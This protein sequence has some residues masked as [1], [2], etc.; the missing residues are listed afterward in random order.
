MNRSHKAQLALT[1]VPNLATPARTTVRLLE[2][3]LAPATPI[4]ELVALVRTDPGLA[5]EVLRKAPSD[6]RRRFS[7]HLVNAVEALGAERLKELALRLPLEGS[8]SEA[9]EPSHTSS[10]RLAR[11]HAL[12][13]AVAAQSFARALDY[14]APETAYAGGLLSS[15]G[16]LTLAQLHAA[17]LAGIADRLAGADIERVLALEQ[18]AC[19]IDHYDLACAL[20]DAWKLPYELRDV[21]EGLHM[22]TGELDELASNGADVT[23]VSLVRA[24]FHAA[25]Q[26]GFPLLRDFAIGEVP[27][28]VA[29]LFESIELPRFLDDVRR[30]VA[31]AVQLSRPASREGGQVV[32]LML[33][34]QSSLRSRLIDADRRLQSEHS[35]S[36]VL[37]YGLK[38]LGEND[39]LPG[40]M[41]K[42]MEALDLSRVACL[43]H[44][45]TEQ[46]LT[47]R[48]SCSRSGSARATEGTWIPLPDD[49]G[50]FSAPGLLS[51]DTDN[52]AAQLVLEL[53]GAPF[54]VIAPLAEIEPGHR[55]VLC[56][57]R[58]PGGE[59]PGEIERRALDLVAEQVSLILQYDRVV[60]E[61]ERMA[62]Q[63]PL[64][65]AA[66][67]RR[68][69]DR[70]EFLISQSERTG[71]PFTLLI[72]DLDH[73]K[74]FNDTM[75]HQTG[76]R[77]LQDLVTL[78]SS[79]VRKGDL[80][81]RYGGE[82]FVVLL[83][84]CDLPSAVE[85]ADALR[86][87]VFEYGT[88]SLDSYQGMQVSISMGA[89][90]WKRC[91]TALSLIGRAD[92]ALYEAKR[93]G[94]NRVVPSA[95]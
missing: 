31:D 87:R 94:R 75:G 9:E 43:E 60:R 27:A 44:D 82:E 34:V 58:G 41:Y 71:L 8:P 3:V 64:T 65:G 89:A 23:L 80:V 72:M 30:A 14:P 37:H 12:A 5:L 67:R 1:S 91:E 53:C 10:A 29:R 22:A 46:R 25:H 24:G 42:A 39:P 50:L 88:R 45:L 90:Q 40:L 7:L 48:R 59:P 11:D 93:G 62:T 79:N 33:D 92:A 78:L 13:V 19:G 83:N 54:A 4:G 68:L 70:L 16:S 84:N 86:Q 63:D 49:R 52:G 77:L 6:R 36:E 21:L 76:D 73:F 2:L 32:G 55:L 74:R 18:E 85:V 56:G 69:M 61:K 35:V 81:A 57:D 15:L 28:D 17:P 20:I 26:A 47:V 66:T 38:R 51:Q 95:A